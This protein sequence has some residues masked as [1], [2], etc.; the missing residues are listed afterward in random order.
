[1]YSNLNT[2]EQNESETGVF[3]LVTPSQGIDYIWVHI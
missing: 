1:M 3:A 2:E